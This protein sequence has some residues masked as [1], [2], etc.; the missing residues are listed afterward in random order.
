MT[1]E[2]RDRLAK[3]M[4]DEAERID[5]GDAIN[6][7]SY[8]MRWKASGMRRAANII[9]E[10]PVDDPWVSVKDRLPEDK[11]TVAFVVAKETSGIDAGRVLGGR[12]MA[13]P[14]GGFGIPGIGG[15]YVSFWMP[16]PP[17]PDESV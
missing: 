13:G 1:V 9:R 3:L 17:P 14:Y 10:Q 4:D 8:S 2:E 7:Q 12:F 16:L 5:P 15:F 6:T 11:Q